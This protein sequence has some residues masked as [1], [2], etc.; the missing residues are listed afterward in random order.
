MWVILLLCQVV[1]PLAESKQEQ[2][3]EQLTLS[4][5]WWYYIQRHGIIL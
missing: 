5:N 4:Q 2:C 1:L 3:K